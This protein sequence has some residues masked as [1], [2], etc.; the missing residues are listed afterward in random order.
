MNQLI[1]KNYIT[2]G[3][4]S[5]RRIAKFGAS[6]GLIVQAAAA[7]DALIGVVDTPG[8]AASGTRA[9]IVHLGITEVEFGGA[10][11]RGGWVTADADGKA[12]APAPAAGANVRVVGFALASAVSGDIGLIFV[13]PGQIQG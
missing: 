2:G 6:D 7:A 8:G 5:Q 11:T 9:D 13:Q 4:V 10:V 3:A 1:V 12:V